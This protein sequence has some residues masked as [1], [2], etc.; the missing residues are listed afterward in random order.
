MTTHH[1]GAPAPGVPLLPMPVVSWLRKS[2][3]ASDLLLLHETDKIHIT[4]HRQLT[5]FF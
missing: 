5:M 1:V 2:G 4:N 3:V